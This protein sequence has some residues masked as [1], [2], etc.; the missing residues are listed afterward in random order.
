MNYYLLKRDDTWRLYDISV[1]G[2]RMLSTYKASFKERVR[3]A[4]MDGL[5][6]HLVAVNSSNAS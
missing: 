3:Q 5:I 2:V 1:A 6:Q 4:G